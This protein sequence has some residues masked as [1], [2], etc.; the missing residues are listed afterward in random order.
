MFFP[1]MQLAADEMYRVLK[2]GGRIALTV[3]GAPDFNNWVTTIMNVIR[4]H[5]ELPPP[6]PGAPGM[7]R[8]APPHLMT[9]ILKQ[10]GFKNIKEG[11]IAGKMDYK[12]FDIYWEMMLEVGAPIVAALANANDATQALIKKETAELFQSINKTGEA[13]LDYQALIISGEK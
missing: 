1:D 9:N 12:S 13:T 4:K 10:A 7:F 5:I 8:C 11:T 2:T 3:W 6:I